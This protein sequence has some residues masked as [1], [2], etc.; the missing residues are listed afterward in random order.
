M[1]P[2][3][4]LSVAVLVLTVPG[5]TSNA[6]ALDEQMTFVPWTGGTWKS[7][8]PGVEQ[9]TYFYQWSHDLV[10]WHY[11]PYMAFGT[12]GHE[13]FM[14]SSPDKLFVRLHRHD[15]SSV[16]TLQQAKD[17]DFD[18]DGLSNWSE[19]FSEGTLPFGWDTDGDLIPDG[20][21]VLLGSLP[22]INSAAGDDDGDGMNNAEEY[23][24]GRD[25][26]GSDPVADASARQL[27]V[28][29]LSPF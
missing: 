14:E 10:I 29:N 24:S 1:K 2:S 20:L 5:V 28:F 7:E 27:D 18:G 25:P 16:T 12:G 6:D 17:A 26:G 4:K 22:L 3:L 9:R 13:F 15:D 19:V 23:L 21:E 8:W 11:A